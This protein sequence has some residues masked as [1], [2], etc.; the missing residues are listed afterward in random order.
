MPLKAENISVKKQGTPIIRA[1]ST[2][3]GKGQITAL[4]GPNGCGKST[5]LRT[6]AG[7]QQPTSGRVEIEGASI[8]SWPRRALAKKLAYL[9]QSPITPE[10]TTVEQLV[11]FGRYSHH[12]L[13]GRKGERD[14][15]AVHWA[16]EATGLLKLRHKAVETLSGGQRQRAW[17]AMT[18]AQQSEIVLLDEPTSFL[19]LRYQ[20][21]V[22]NLVKSLNASHGLTICWVLHDLNQALHFSHRVILMAEGS[23][24]AEGAPQEVLTPAQ[25]ERVFGIEMTPLHHP[26]HGKPSL[27]PNYAA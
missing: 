17:I 5:L 14:R 13:L 24:Q 21:E 27:H 22:L 2:T 7:Q 10:H 4:V 8:A 20:I 16:L 15:A 11:G 23:I 18:L 12:G 3:L 19:D 25:V 1:L 26:K 9:P 6:L